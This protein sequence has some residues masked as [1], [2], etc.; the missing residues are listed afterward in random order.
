MRIKEVLLS[1]IAATSIM[2]AFSYLAS[3]RK[4]EN[5]REPLLLAGLINSLTTYRGSRKRLEPCGWLL[6]YSMGAAWSPIEY[7][8]LRQK[9]GKSDVKDSAAFGIFGGVCGLL[10]WDLM[11]KVTKYSPDTNK[12]RFYVHLVLAHVIYGIALQQVMKAQIRFQEDRKP[13]FLLP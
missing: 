5:Y 9:R 6:H 3:E 2:T 12:R 1:S 13:R 4:K 8:F 7:L 10:I 11:F